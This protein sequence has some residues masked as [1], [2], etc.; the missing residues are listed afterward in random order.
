[1][2]RLKVMIPIFSSVS[3]NMVWYAMGCSAMV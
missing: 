3:V 1:L 2:G